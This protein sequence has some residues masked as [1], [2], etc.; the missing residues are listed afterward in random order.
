MTKSL[1]II[2]MVFLLS[3]AG[4]GE[5]TPR[6]AD[7]VQTVETAETVPETPEPELVLYPEGTLDPATVSQNRVISAVDLNRAVFAWDGA[8]VTVVAFPYIWYGDETTVEGELRLVM[9]PDSRDEL[10]TV[11]FAQPPGITVARGELMAVQGTVSRRF[12]RVELSDTRLVDPPETIQRIET[13][14]W[15]YDGEPIPLDQFAEYHEAWKGMEVTVEGYYNSTTTSTTD[16]GVTVRVDL[17]DPD[18]TS[19]K[20][21]ECEMAEAVSE[22]VNGN[23][24]ANRRGV[25]I[26]GVI[27]GTSFR[28]VAL[29]NCRVV[30]R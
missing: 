29:E 26:R 23:M 30:N 8:E 14:P 12:Q 10:I 22:D 6:A 21:V 25:Q 18:N 11:R 13:S 5:E 7:A 28:N 19:A 1:P 24:V 16:Y 3:L 2:P 20:V 15:V 27:T 9:D 4:C 17:S